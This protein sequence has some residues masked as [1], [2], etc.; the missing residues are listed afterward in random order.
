MNRR[1][2]GVTLAAVVLSLAAAVVLL[3]AL[4]PVLTGLFGRHASTP[5][6]SPASIL[7]ILIVTAFVYLL[8]AGCGITTVVGLFRM[9]PWARISMLVIGALIA[10][11]GIFSTLMCF[12]MPSL[13]RAMPL[14]PNTNPAAVRAVFTLMALFDMAIAAVGAWWLIY[15][16]LRS[17]REAFGRQPAAPAFN[18]YAPPPLPHAHALDFSEAQPLPVYTPAPPPLYGAAYD[19]PQHVI[20]AAPKRPVSM[21]ILAVVLGFACLSTLPAIFLGH[22]Q[23]ILLGF[24]VSGGA[25]RLGFAV[26]FVWLGFTAAGLIALRKSAWY[27]AVAYCLYAISTTIVMML[28]YGRAHMASYVAE[29]QAHAAM[30]VPQL[31]FN[32]FTAPLFN[33]IMLPALALTIM[34]NLAFLVL[35][36]R[37]RYAFTPEHA[38]T[39]ER[40]SR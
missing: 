18:P 34:L 5:A 10:L 3:L 20:T 21:T 23:M 12:A 14:P 37:A 17:T 27:A 35:L 15:F 33:L 2:A 38:F 22:S 25:A 19:P 30:G 6:A 40:A 11:F 29:R 9:R 36:Y 4:L 28:P 32:P 7:A 1:P 8:V 13:L 24:F 16:A 31:A 39:A 26:M